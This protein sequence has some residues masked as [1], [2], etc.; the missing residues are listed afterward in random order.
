[1]LEYI[2]AGGY[3]PDPDPRELRR[4]AAQAADELRAY[5]EDG[6]EEAPSELVEG[7]EDA[8]AEER[9]RALHR[10]DMVVG[11]ADGS[12]DGAGAAALVGATREALVNA[13]KHARATRVVV[14]C[15]VER[16][17]ALVTVFDDGIGFD[18]ARTEYRTG[19]RESVAARMARHGGSAHVESWPG[20]GTLVSLTVGPRPAGG[21]SAAMLPS[22]E[23]VA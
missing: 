17:G 7:L 8:V 18:P 11:H 6:A 15:E 1:V 10:L 13:R 16:G 22:P 14:Y 20:E 12:A 5:I 2:A 3:R 4:A 9:Q 21:P 19:L 23:A